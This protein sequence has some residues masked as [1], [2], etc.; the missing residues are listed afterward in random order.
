[1]AEVE[2]KGFDDFSEFNMRKPAAAIHLEAPVKEL[3][4]EELHEQTLAQAKQKE[5]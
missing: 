3:S 1:M 2:V 5:E 4:H